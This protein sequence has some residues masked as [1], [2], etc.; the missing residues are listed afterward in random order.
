[1]LFTEESVNGEKE[2]SDHKVETGWRREKMWQQIVTRL[3]WGMTRSRLGRSMQIKTKKLR[4]RSHWTWWWVVG[5]SWEGGVK[6]K[7]PVYNMNDQQELSDIIGAI[8]HNTNLFINMLEK[9]WQKDFKKKERKE[10]GEGERKEGRKKEKENCH[11]IWF[12]YFSIFN[13]WL[14]NN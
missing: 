13:L 2:C 7:S 11:K 4:S 1:M 9:A 3:W 5:D 8:C 10:R 12:F 14:W 6:I